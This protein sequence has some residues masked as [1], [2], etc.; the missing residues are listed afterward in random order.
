MLEF[1][2]QNNSIASYGRHL[3]FNKFVRPSLCLQ[4]SF[5]S[6]KR[7]SRNIGRIESCAFQLTLTS[8]VQ[9]TEIISKFV[10][11]RSKDKFA[12]KGGLLHLQGIAMKHIVT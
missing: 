5:S 4:V 2:K 1:L 9:M 7:L 6:A 11:I 10:T 8:T 3:E 12:L